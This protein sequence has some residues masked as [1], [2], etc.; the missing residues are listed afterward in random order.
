MNNPRN[1]FWQNALQ[2]DSLSNQKKQQQQ[3][4]KPTN[5]TNNNNK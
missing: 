3:T 1:V 4:N 5:Q 2:K